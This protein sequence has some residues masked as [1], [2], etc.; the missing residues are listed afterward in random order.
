MSRQSPDESEPGLSVRKDGEL[1]TTDIPTRK[2]RRRHLRQA[3]GLSRVCYR[4]SSGVDPIVVE[5]RR[6]TG[7]VAWFVCLG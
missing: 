1:F 6:R 2:H 5:C 7:K 3:L 4:G